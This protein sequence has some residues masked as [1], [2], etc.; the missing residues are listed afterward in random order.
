MLETAKRVCNWGK[1]G[2]EDEVGTVNY[3]TSEDIVDAAKLIKKGKIFS[4]GM[5]FDENGP[6][7]GR[8][9]RTNPV[10]TMTFTGTDVEMGR[11]QAFLGVDDDKP[12]YSNL[13]ADDYISM[14][15]QCA[16]HWDALGHV[17]YQDFEKNEV[18]MYGGYSPKYVDAALGCT[19]SGI[20]KVK[21]K[22]AG[23]GV[24]LDMARF[25]KKEYMDPGEGITSEDL[26]ACAKLQGVTIQK[27]DFLLIRT[28]HLGRHLKQ[29]SWDGFVAG[30]APGVEFE[31]IVW[32]HDK[33]IAA[34]AVDTWCAEVRPNRSDVFNQPWHW[35]CLPIVGLTMGEMF[36]LDELAEDC[37]ADKQYEFFFVAP[38]LAI[39]NATGSPLNPYAI[40]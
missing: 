19:R 21:D 36:K 5:N 7:T 15:I 2:K 12:W 35:L 9:K 17:F 27:G 6:Q 31:T 34:V 24:L 37:E 20:D 14:P 16:T 30:D 1:W 23:R 29:K 18:F 25:K 28:G 10:H 39:T 22:M 3:V 13:S 8:R 26:D 11:Q 40:K 32:M 4:L 33:E 38:P